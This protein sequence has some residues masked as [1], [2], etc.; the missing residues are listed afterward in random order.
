LTAAI[1][2]LSD[3][4]IRWQCRRGTKELDQLLLDWFDSQYRLASERQKSAFHALLELQDP[5]L[6]AYLI[7]GA[8]PESPELVEVVNA[9]CR[10]DSP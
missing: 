1:R 7:Q 2:R 4:R 3:A 6:I 8:R 9:I 10:S 5:E